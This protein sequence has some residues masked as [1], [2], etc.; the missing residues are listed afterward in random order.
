M[1]DEE[2][3]LPKLYHRMLVWQLEKKPRALDVLDLATQ[4]ACSRGVALDRK[5]VDLIGLVATGRLMPRHAPCG[6]DKE[7]RKVI[8][9]IAQSGGASASPV[10]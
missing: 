8:T 4:D 1:R 3:P 10:G 7:Q 6:D 2:A 9:S 5:S